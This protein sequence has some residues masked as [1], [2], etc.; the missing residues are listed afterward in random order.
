MA[1][2]TIEWEGGRD[3]RMKI[4]DQTL[5]PGKL[6]F[7]YC[8]DVKTVWQAIKELK[9]R[10]AP[11]IGIAAAMGTY[12]GI[13][14]TNTNN[15]ETFWK[16]LKEVTDYLRTSRPTAVNLFWALER[17]EHA[18]QAY[19]HEPV[20]TLKEMLFEE[21]LEILEED[22]DSSRAIGRYGAELI[23]EGSTVMTY[24]N[25]GGLATGGYGTALAVI[26]AAK[27]TGKDIKV[28][29]CETRPLLQGARLTSWELLQHGLDVTLICDNMVAHVMGEG[30]VDLV[31]ID[32]V[33]ML[34]PETERESSF[35]DWATGLHP[36]LV[37]RFA[38]VWGRNLDHLRWKEKE[39]PPTLIV[40]NQVR[41]KVGVVYGNP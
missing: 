17:M 28:Y 40:I 4:I 7:I 27:D 2:P 32:S 39:R 29:A 21:A 34:S 14:G 36:R 31:I 16:R 8:D 5:L 1:I 19:S 35:Y 38:R 26:Y 9:V 22:R 20:D 3:G 13:K 24:C 41:E 30:R 11:A 25:A 15:F 6:E 18:A 10:G 12:V 23:R 37:T 33:A